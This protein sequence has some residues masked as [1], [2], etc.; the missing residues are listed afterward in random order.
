MMAEARGAPSRRRPGR[1]ACAPTS[2]PL[3]L[4]A[5]GVPTDAHGPRRGRGQAARQ[6]DALPRD[7][8]RG[9]RR[10]SSFGKGESTI[11]ARLPLMV[12]PSPPRFLNF[13]DTFELP[14]VVQN[15]TD[16]PM[17]VDVAVR[18]TNADLDAP[19]AG[20]RVTVPRATTASRCASRPRRSAPGTARFQVGGVVGHAAP[21]PPSSRCRCGRR[22]RPRR[23]RP[24]AR[25]T[26]ARSRSR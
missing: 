20:Q 25:S 22:R 15:Q 7:G 14:V 16:A 6:P 1:S 11:T 19:G 13:G 9:R 10:A 26:R 24:T 2:T 18:A 23:S 8:G 17:T 3:A 5:A 4:F 21:T 12:R